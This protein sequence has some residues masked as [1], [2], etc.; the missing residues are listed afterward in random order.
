MSPEIE[1]MISS[2]LT[3]LPR[4]PTTSQIK[5]PTPTTQ[6]LQTPQTFTCESEHVGTRYRDLVVL[7][8]DYV[9]VYAWKDGRKIAIAY[10]QRS[11]MAGE[12]PAEVLEPVESQPVTGSEVC[13][14]FSSSRRQ[15]S[16]RV[17]DLTWEGGDYIR[18]CKWDNNLFK[19]SGHGFN[20]STR[21]IG[22]FIISAN[23]V[24][25]VRA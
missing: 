8:G 11:D 9:V 4:A 24:K 21:D 25:V 12:V 10:N 19:D 15:D 22:R 1:E 6:V 2:L 18:I 16:R 5:V 14:F 23:D 17:G 7:P 13:M 3:V 20:L